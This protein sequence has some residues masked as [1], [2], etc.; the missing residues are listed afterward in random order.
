MPLTALFRCDASPRIGAGHATR[1]LAL[2]EALAREGWRTIFATTSES[3]ATVP[4]L[5]HHQVVR[6]GGSP[7]DE[8]AE[9]CAAVKGPVDWLVVDHNGRDEQF[10]SA[11]RASAKHIL[12]IADFADRHHDCDL[13]LDQTIGRESEAD[14]GLHRPLVP[15]H[16]ALLL[17]LDY[18]LVRNQFTRRRTE[19]KELRDRTHEAR[20]VLMSFG[21]T[22]AFGLTPRI[23]AALLARDPPFVI[24]VVTGAKPGAELSSL[25]GRH[26]KHVTLHHAVEDMGSLLLAADLAV[27]LAGTSGS[28]RCTLGLPSALFSPSERYREISAR[29]TEAGACEIVGHESF[30]DAEAIAAILVLAGNKARL[31]GMAAAAFSLCDGLGASRTA[32]DMLAMTKARQ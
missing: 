23:L 27:G 30:D 12:V 24:D 4:A 25:V 15:S 19:A 2:A 18:A 17:G 28:E 10:E 21:G 20:R 14:R 16:C 7:L 32:A 6:V 9:I 1:S 8:P 26:A 3:V 11:C 29:F 31:A 13:L 5:A 22:D